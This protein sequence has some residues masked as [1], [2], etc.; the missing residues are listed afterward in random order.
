MKE[1][2]WS[3]YEGSAPPESPPAPEEEDPLAGIDL[4]FMED[5][6]LS[7]RQISALLHRVFVVHA[8]RAAAGDD[9][10]ARTIVALTER[11]SKMR[12][13]D[14]PKEVAMEVRRVDLS[15]YAKL[16]TAE[17]ERLLAEM[18]AIPST[19]ERIDDN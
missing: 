2:M 5:P 13:F 12:G 8:R 4:A 1:E 17:L 11:I 6:T 10:A 19:S 7:H 18:Q 3:F 14:A 16:P 15:D 9:R